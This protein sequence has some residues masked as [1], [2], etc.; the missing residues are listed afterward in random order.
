MKRSFKLGSLIITLMLGLPSIEAAGV[1]K[2][3]GKDLVTQKDVDAKIKEL[4]LTSAPRDQV[5]MPLL[6]R[7]AEERLL[8]QRM[9]AAKLESDVEFKKEAEANAEDFKR[10]YYLQQ[11]A[12]KRITLQMRQSVYEQFKA[13]VKDKKEVSPKIIVLTD[14]KKASEIHSKLM[15]GESFGD[16]AKEHSIDPSKASGGEIGRFLPEE[17]FSPE[18]TKALSE[19]KE[20]ETSKP[21]KSSSANGDVHIIVRIDKGMRRDQVLPPLESPEMK[22]QIDQVIIRQMVGV[23]QTDLLRELEVYDLQGNKIPL[24]QEKKDAQEG[25]PLIGGGMRKS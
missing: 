5:F 23:V 22:R 13:T 6:V 8:S 12:A 4:N 2:H 18:V 21:I 17:A 20:C 3:K 19:M 14:E 16:L 1:V 15:K 9:I 11:E 10:N 24:V 7:L 25:I